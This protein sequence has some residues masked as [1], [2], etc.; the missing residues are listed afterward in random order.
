VFARPNSDDP[1]H[2]RGHGGHDGHGGHGGNVV[3]ANLVFA[4]PE[5][6]F[7]RPERR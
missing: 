6:V 5:L 7:A 2:V 4:R 3:G 1:R